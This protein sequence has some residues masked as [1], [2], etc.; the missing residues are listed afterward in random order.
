MN[1][2]ELRKKSIAF[3][4]IRIK[5]AI[6]EDVFVIQLVSHIEDLDRVINIL[7]KRLR[8]WYKLTLPEISNM[9]TDQKDFIDVIRKE[10]KALMQKF[11]IT[12][13]MGKEFSN[14]DME[15]LELLR[16]ECENLII[17]REKQTR[18][19]T[20]LMNQ[21]YPNLTT[22]A[23]GLIG[24]KLIELAGGIKDLV[25]F[26]ASTIQLLGAEKALFRHI[27]V[28]AKPPKYGILLGHEYVAISNQKA[29]AARQLADKISIAVKID[30]FKGK[31]MGDKLKSML[32]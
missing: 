26:P 31:F 10:R 3:T 32:K 8:D 13:S 9:I 23:G 22:L 14:K 11:K 17:L 6:G 12:E 19:L 5:E 7:T 1:L 15:S 20:D 25:E 29:K 21:H 27:K 18:K 2:Q 30:Y 16:K 4:K 28:G 24:G